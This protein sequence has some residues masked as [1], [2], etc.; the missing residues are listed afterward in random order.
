MASYGAFQVP[1]IENE[2]VKSFAPNSGD[3]TALA[4]ALTSLESQLPIRIPLVIGGSRVFT[5]STV[6]NVN[7]AKHG[8]VVGQTSQATKE[9][10]AQA[11]VASQVAKR[12]WESAP[13]SVRSAVFLKAAELIATKYRYELLAATMI[14]QGKN[15]YQAEIDAAAELI[16][17]LR[18]NC[19]YAQEL[20]GQQPIKSAPGVWNRAEYRALE[21]FVYAITPF[22]FTAIAGNLV[23]APALMGNTVLWKPSPYAVLSNY[24]LYNIFVEA[25]LPD[26]VI[27]FVPGDAEAVTAE[28]LSARSFGA[29]HYTGSTAVFE[30]LYKTIATNLPKYRSFPRIVGESGGKN[31]HLIHASADVTSAAKSTVRGAFEY[32]GQKCSATSR[33][34]VPAS[35][36]PE[37]RDVLV[38]ETKALTVGPPTD[39]TPF[40]GPVIHQQSFN[41]LKS[42]LAALAAD[43]TVE[44]IVGGTTDDAVGY[45]VMPTVVVASDPEHY[46][47][48]QEFFGPVLSVYVYA[49]DEYEAIMDA[50]DLATDYALTGSVYAKSRDAIEV[51]SRKLRNTAGNFYINDKSTGAVVGQQWFGGARR[52]GT[53]DK[54]G[55]G[56]ILSRFVS[57]RN[58]KETFYDTTRV[59]YPSNE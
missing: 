24:L 2:E 34:Y 36:W 10:V 7:P 46:V 52:S 28:V 6:P 22:N 8:Q 51:A 15:I 20:Y 27:N 45:Y 35:I 53:N 33:A 4:A 29:L 58:I 49:D 14:G 39:L 1:P 26:G 41:K 50:I 25:G 21:G 19:Q 32:Q 16:D 43:K 30:H 48:C 31:F 12:K 44:I 18:F 56:N 3:R 54:S 59:T 40:V 17:F 55:S 11:I 57:V 47:F 13:L 23:A 37:F 5:E 42:I 9:H 38:R